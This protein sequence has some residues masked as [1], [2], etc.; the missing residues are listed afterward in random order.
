MP[1]KLQ[2]STIWHPGL[3]L[4]HSSVP[5]DA[6]VEQILYVHVFFFFFLFVFVLEGVN[7]PVSLTKF[8]QMLT[9]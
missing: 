6:Y 8:L 7:Y 9:N 2:Y 1:M 3:L 5:H 4:H